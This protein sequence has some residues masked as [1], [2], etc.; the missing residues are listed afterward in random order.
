MK[1]LRIT[2]IRSQIDRPVVQKRTIVALGIKKLNRPIEVE[3]TPQ[4]LGMI[5]TVKHLLKVEEI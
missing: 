2:Q 4:I 1:K 5:D 3:A